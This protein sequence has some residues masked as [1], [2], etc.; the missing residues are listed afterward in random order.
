MK[1]FNEWLN[2]ATKKM[3]DEAFDAIKSYI[4][5]NDMK[6][7]EGHNKEY[8]E[9]HGVASVSDL[10]EMLKKDRDSQVEKQKRTDFSQ[11]EP[12]NDSSADSKYKMQDKLE[13]KARKGK[14]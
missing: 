7:L 2:E 4:K 14:N 12:E 11:E 6:H 5:S 13:R 9:Q 8:W 1:T 3:S 10:K